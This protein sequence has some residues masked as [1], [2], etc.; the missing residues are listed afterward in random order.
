MSDTPPPGSSPASP[1]PAAGNSAKV[2]AIVRHTRVRPDA[3]A[4]YA[5]WRA[6]LTTALGEQT[7]FLR[8]EVYPPDESQP[9]WVTVERFDTV[10]HAQGWLQSEARIALA[11][12]VATLVSGPDSVTMLVGDGPSQP[13]DVTA[14]I[15]NRPKPGRETEFREWQRRIQNAQSR[16]PGYRGV[17][18]QP[19][20]PGITEDWVTLLRFDTA[21]RLRAW[22]ES[23][24]C[25]ELT[26]ES[27]EFLDVGTYR[28]ARTTFANWLPPDEQAVNPSPWKVNAIV[29]LV[30]YPLVMLEIIFLYPRI[31]FLGTGPM[32][33]VGNVI[34]V[35]ATGFFLVPW[36]ARAL[37]R[38][39]SP[40]GPVSP[41]KAVL[42]WAAMGASYALLILIMSLL[43]NAVLG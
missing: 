7:G 39:L 1:D 23:E 4:D 37:Q 41:A 33:F 16:F 3:T 14:V 2:A 34:G 18:V 22:Q 6:R 11:A 17:E 27:E 5:M 31:G 12:D 10:D 13:R 24:V 29:L 40:E 8:L 28:V 36:A 43:A 20:I 38:W 19:P 35:Y 42:G 15:T 9:D 30:L 25:Q 32:T 21:E 26:R